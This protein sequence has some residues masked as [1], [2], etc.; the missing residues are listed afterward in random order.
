MRGLFLRQVNVKTE[1]LK[2]SAQE[3]LSTN[4]GN[5]SK[6]N[7]PKIV[8]AIPCFN[9]ALY[10]ADVVTKA[11]RYVDQVIVIDDG[12]QD[13]T[14][15]IA[16]QAGAFVI[17]HKSNLG[18][19]AAM[20]TAAKAIDVDDIIVFID[21]DGQH[22]PD[23]I[24]RLVQPIIDG[25]A[26]MVIG[27]RCLPESKIEVAPKLRRLANFLA[28]YVITFIISF[29]LPL[30]TMFKC[31]MKY[32]RITDCTSGFRAIRIDCWEKLSIKSVKY[33]I[34]TEMIFEGA[35]HN[36]RIMESPIKC[37]WDA[38]TSGLSVYKDALTTTK[39]LIIKLLTCKPVHKATCNVK[40][41]CAEHID[42]KAKL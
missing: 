30:R 5:V 17:S 20:K 35:K 4:D 39:L 1:Q 23:D 37:N 15:E 11:K 33:E 25:N 22:N 40:K 42:I 41:P 2:E 34:E 7:H 27:S 32:R 21:G 24:T 31:P 12:S 28:S 13:D 16:R 18:K 29:L 38:E 6:Q 10:I 14:A 9:T 3:T 26:D 36:L 8:A 19:G